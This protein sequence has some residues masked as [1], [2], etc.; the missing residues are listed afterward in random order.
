MFLF[1]PRKIF[2]KIKN[3]DLNTSYVLIYHLVIHPVRNR[4]TFK[5]IL[6]SYLSSTTALK[7]TEKAIFKYILCSYLSWLVCTGK[8]ANKI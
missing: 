1:I 6:C 3:N 4:C 8:L 7:S 5:Y 2:K